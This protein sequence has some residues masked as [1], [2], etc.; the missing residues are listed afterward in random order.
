MALPELAEIM[1]SF[2][3]RVMDLGAPQAD[4]YCRSPMT[5]QEIEQV[6]ACYSPRYLS[7]EYEEFLRLGSFSLLRPPDLDDHVREN[8]YGAR[9]SGSEDQ[10]IVDRM[11]AGERHRGNPL[12]QNWVLLGSVDSWWYSTSLPNPAK[13]SSVLF[14]DCGGPGSS[15]VVFPS[16][17]SLLWT[18]N[19]MLADVPPSL[20]DGIDSVIF[21]LVNWVPRLAQERSD[22][23]DWYLEAI[24]R[25]I[26]AE[27]E[28][29]NWVEDQPPPM[30]ERDW[31]MEW[32]A[33]C[34]VAD[35]DLS[36]TGRPP[37]PQD[38][39]QGVRERPD[40]HTGGE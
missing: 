3:E 19:E 27:D 30:D 17:R 24:R 9:L 37:T 23:G 10:R 26:A 20:N 2:R 13:R 25:G 4:H 29:G 38:H 28:S 12:S 36:P 32:L 8:P 31:T 15:K 35:L 22:F 6:R 18:W 1:E 33:A 11:L 39:S 21:G 14:W 40:H 5:E 16:I 7:D 34:G